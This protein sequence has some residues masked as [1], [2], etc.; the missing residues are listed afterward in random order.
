MRPS[1]RRTSPLPQLERV[2]HTE[3]SDP[4]ML[5]RNSENGQ[6]QLC[7][8]LDFPVAAWPPRAYVPRMIT[9]DKREDEVRQAR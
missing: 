8:A 5:L 1:E 4:C 2:K 6:A 7:R 3:G 9:K